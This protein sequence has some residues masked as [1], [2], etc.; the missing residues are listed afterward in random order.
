[1]R[2]S[3][4]RRPQ[5]RHQQAPSLTRLITPEQVGDFFP[6]AAPNWLRQY[7]DTGRNFACAIQVFLA[8]NEQA[9]P[10]LTAETL[11][12]P[13]RGSLSQ[14]RGRK[15]TG[16]TSSGALSRNTNFG[17]PARAAATST[18]LSMLEPN[19]YPGGG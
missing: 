1:M 12:I 9:S 19:R 2:L 17:F 18:D 10:E 13:K 14:S 7:R 6:A 3:Q 15:L 16:L 11:Q 5:S 8:P 4:R